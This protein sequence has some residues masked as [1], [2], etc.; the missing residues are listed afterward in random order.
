MEKKEAPEE[1]RARAEGWGKSATGEQVRPCHISHF[2][3]RV[4]GSGV[5]IEVP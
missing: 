2:R 3:V 5:W 1:D 4:L